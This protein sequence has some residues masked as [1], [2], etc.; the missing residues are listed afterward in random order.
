[1]RADKLTPKHTKVLNSYILEYG[2]DAV[3]AYQSVYTKAKDGCARSRM[4]RLLSRDNAKAYIQ[5]LIDSLPVT[6][7]ITIDY[8]IAGLKNLAEHGSVESNKLRAYELLGKYLKL[9]RD[10]EITTSILTAEDYASIRTALHTV[11]TTDKDG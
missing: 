11:R 7:T 5:V 6:K 4:N 2:L 3:R 8:V 10:T 9:F 1:M